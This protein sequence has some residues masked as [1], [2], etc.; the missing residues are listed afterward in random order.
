VGASRVRDLFSTA[1][2]TGKAI[3]FID[4][5]DAI[6]RARGAGIGGGHDEREQTLNQILVEMDG[7]EKYDEQIVIAATNRP[8]ILDPALMRPGR[9]DRRVVLDLPDMNDREAILHIHARGKPMSSDTKMREIAERTPGFSGADL[10]NLVN[11]AAILAA[12]RNKTQVGQNELLE[13][14]DKVM[15]GPERKSH[16][17]SVKEKEIAAFHEAGHAVVSSKLLQSEPV[18]K[19]SIVS[20]GFAAGYMLKLPSQ[21][22]KFKTKKD[23]EAELAILLGGY[24]AEEIVF[25]NIT[26][27]ATN[28]LEKASELTRKLIKEYGMSSMG[29]VFLGKREELIFLGKEIADEKNYSE[30]VASRIDK[31]MMETIL[32]AKVSAMKV[33][34][35]NRTTLEKIARRLIEKETIEKEEFDQLMKK[36]G[37][38]GGTQQKKEKKKS[39]KME[40]SPIE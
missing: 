31:E 21:E 33:L 32:R 1:K 11:E 38:G 39:I 12:R 19:L 13:S 30:Q 16:V 8:D 26:T 18:R 35:T 40:T 15:L 22:K 27:G 24:C 7:F 5:L 28:D 17:L 36:S 14:I 34:K 3:I 10:A 37:K 20:R 29:P 9:F 6:G 23:F 2:K 25:G 4:E